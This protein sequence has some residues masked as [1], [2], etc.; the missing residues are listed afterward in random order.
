MRVVGVLYGALWEPVFTL[1]GGEHL[2]T[3][4][5]SRCSLLAW[6]EVVILFH[7]VWFPVCACSWI[8]LLCTLQHAL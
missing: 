7:C 1:S 5:H 4:H 6:Q 3:A 8:T 2:K